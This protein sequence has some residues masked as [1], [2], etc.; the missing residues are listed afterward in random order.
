MLIE[1]RHGGRAVLPADRRDDALIVR[2]N[3]ERVAIAVEVCD[4]GIAHAVEASTEGFGPERLACPAACGVAPEL[5]RGIHAAEREDAGLTTGRR[6]GHRLVEDVRAR[7]LEGLHAPRAVLAHQ[8]LDACATR[9][10]ID[11]PVLD[12]EGCVRE[13]EAAREGF[14]GCGRGRRRARRR[15]RGLWRWR[16]RRRHGRRGLTATAACSERDRE[17][18]EGERA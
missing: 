8:H 9:C 18:G 5:H 1:A 14:A 4:L 12:R 15:R 2:R 3:R 16:G 10:G 13:Q 6:E 11:L 7:V 17:G